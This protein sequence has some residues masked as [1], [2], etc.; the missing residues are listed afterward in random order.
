MTS[1]IFNAPVGQNAYQAV[2]MQAYVAAWTPYVRTVNRYCSGPSGANRNVGGNLSGTEQSCMPQ[3]PVRCGRRLGFVPVGGAAVGVGFSGGSGYAQGDFVTFAPVNGGRPIVAKI[4][5]VTG[6]AP[7]KVIVID[8]GS[9]LLGGGTGV[10]SLTE[11]T[12]SLNQA[13]TTGVGTGATW[14]ALV[15]VG[16]GNGGQPRSQ[17]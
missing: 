6:G 8:P 13:S 2:V 1:P 3:A 15:G 17:A 4:T 12:A 9:G 5:A 16:L 7:S 11:Q 14:T 10:S